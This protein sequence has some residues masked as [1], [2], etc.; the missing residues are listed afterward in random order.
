MLDADGGSAAD[1]LVADA[2]RLRRIY[3]DELGAGGSAGAPRPVVSDSWQRS[4]AALVDPESRLPPLVFHA[5]ELREVREN[6]PLH[7]VMPLLRNTL[8]SIAD[9]A[10]HVMLVTDADGHVL[11]RDGAHGLMHSADDVGLCEGT[12][13]TED[14][15]GTNAMGTALALDRPMRIHSAEHLV[16][17]Y[18]DWTCVAAPVH[19]PDTGDTIGAIDI[20]GPLHTVHPALVQLVTATAHLAENQL[21][22]RLAIADERLRV[23]NMPHL[24]ALRGAE[25]A[26]LSPSGRVIASEPYGR[27]PER[28]RVEQGVER[29][30]LGDGREMAVEQLSEGYLLVPPSRRR[31]RVTRPA[32]SSLALRFTGGAGPRITLDGT[33]SA[34]TLRPAEILTALALHP[35]GLSGEQLTLMLYGEDGNPTTVRGE[36]H[37]LRSSLG[38]D[39]LLTRPY[40]LAT[41][42]DA[43]FLRM[44][45]ALREG[46]IADALDACRGELLP[47]S[48]AP[49]VRELRDELAAGLRHAILATDDAGLLHR[50][51]GHPLGGDDLQVHERLLD[52]LDRDDPRRPAVAARAERLLT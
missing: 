26:L 34:A 3:D 41:E 29:V 10:M 50:F 38:A 8:V 2:N 16:R 15:I 18:H 24:S 6:H 43:D 11:W 4:L 25:G 51:T 5:D 42:P 40:R 27:F 1:E 35:D 21:R 45:A 31:S 48:D 14:A 30:Q 22:V 33:D 44:R 49:A 28:I 47:R 19:D 20:S 9:E 39:L 12:R 46:R 52:L 23:K 37:R 17:T 13:W 36:I 7:A 32:G